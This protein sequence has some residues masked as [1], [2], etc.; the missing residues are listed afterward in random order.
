VDDV[1][2]GA[3]AADEQTSEEP[4]AIAEGNTCEVDEKGQCQLA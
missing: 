1:A 4:I 3:D 2:A